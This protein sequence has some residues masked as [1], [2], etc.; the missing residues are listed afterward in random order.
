MGRERGRVIMRWQERDRELLALMF[1]GA[2]NLCDLGEARAEGS[3]STLMGE[4]GDEGMAPR[5]QKA[6]LWRQKRQA[7]DDLASRLKTAWAVSEAAA[8]INEDGAGISK[9]EFDELWELYSV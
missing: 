7:I 1:A 3:L 4:N 5:Q 2:K 8:A 9:R 6:N